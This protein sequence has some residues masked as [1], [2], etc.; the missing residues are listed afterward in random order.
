MKAKER[1]RHVSKLPGT[2]QRPGFNVEPMATL[3]PSIIE[4]LCP[5]NAFP[6][7][8]E[9]AILHN[10]NAIVL[11]GAIRTLKTT[12]ICQTYAERVVQGFQCVEPVIAPLFR[13]VTPPACPFT[14]TPRIPNLKEPFPAEFNSCKNSVCMI[15]HKE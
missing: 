11:L 13:A 7:A 1:T 12:H 10:K 6:V 3:H 8:K 15:C 14:S 5:F 4:Q 2:W 9:I